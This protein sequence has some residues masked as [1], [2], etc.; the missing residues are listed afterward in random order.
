MLKKRIDLA[1][2]R[3]LF[4]FSITKT[5]KQLDRKYV[6][7]TETEKKNSATEITARAFFQ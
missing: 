7:Q 2:R 6:S 4:V 1:V 5:M 3:Q